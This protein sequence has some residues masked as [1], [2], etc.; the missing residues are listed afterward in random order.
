M[1]VFTLIWSLLAVV[2]TIFATARRS[3]FI[4]RPPS[5]KEASGSGRGIALVAAF[6]SLA[7]LAG[8]LYLTKFLVSTL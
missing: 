7:L 1:F 2:V 8:F 6:Y 5:T 3:V 4:P